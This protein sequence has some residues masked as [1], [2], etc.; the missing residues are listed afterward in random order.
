MPVSEAGRL[1]DRLAELMEHHYG[2]RHTTLQFETTGCSPDAL[3]CNASQTNH[4]LATE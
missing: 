4:P 3:Y 2:I 1:R